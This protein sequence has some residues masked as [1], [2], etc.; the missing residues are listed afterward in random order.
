MRIVTLIL[1]GLLLV[2]PAVG[3]DEIKV[4]TSGAFTAAYLEIT[5]AFERATHHTITTVYGASMGSTPTSIPN[6]LE[7][8]EPLDVVILADTAL[9]ALIRAGKVMPGS[10]VDLVRSRIGMAVRKGAPKPDIRTVAALTRTL[11]QAKS[12]AFS[13]S[14]SGVYISSELLQRLG[15]AD[16]ILPR[17]T[18][19]QSEPVGAVVARGDAEIGFQQISELL[20][21]KGIDVVGPLPAEVQKITVFSAGIVAG[22]KAPEAARALIAYLAS[23]AAA[24]AI[25]KAGLEPANA[26]LTK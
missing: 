6:R 5:P 24:A 19:V 13:D 26:Q 15:I 14:A 16:R 25:T 22:A 21:E 8:G 10:R 1:A 12:V 17:S 9:D 11:L 7:R 23:P 18:R 2:A 4:V 20:P 3:A